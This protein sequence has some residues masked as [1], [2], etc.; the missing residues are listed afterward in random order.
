MRA[1]TPEFAAHVEAAKAQAEEV[2]RACE[3]GAKLAE[4]C[5]DAE[6]QLNE[7]MR[8]AGLASRGEEES[9]TAAARVVA[10]LD[11]QR[12]L[13]NT[14]LRKL[15]LAATDPAHFLDVQRAEAARSA[16]SAEGLRQ[17][18]RVFAD[19]PNLP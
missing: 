12:V 3:R 8:I 15:N 9:R 18:P 19:E 1:A 14:A 16:A 4:T 17:L 13:A 10:A 6:V 2:V 7:H 5:C 11:K